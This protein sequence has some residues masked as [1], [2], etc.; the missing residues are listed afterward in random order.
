[1]VVTDNFFRS[2]H[3]LKVTE[4][5]NSLKALQC[6]LKGTPVTN[7]KISNEYVLALQKQLLQIY[8]MEGDALT[9][10]GAWSYELGEG[11]MDL[12]QQSKLLG[13]V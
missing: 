2:V 5:E 8:K 9:L 1:M 10:A 3:L 12:L 7:I 13:E 6:L 11:N 4:E